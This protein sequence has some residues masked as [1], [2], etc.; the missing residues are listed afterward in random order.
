[1][2]EEA[3]TDVLITRQKSFS[4]FDVYGANE[5]F[6]NGTFD[7]F[8]PVH[9]VDGR[10]IEKVPDTGSSLGGCWTSTNRRSSARWHV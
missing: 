4:R 7:E 6:V 2:L 8:T 3:E 1:M 5:T 9:A 10:C